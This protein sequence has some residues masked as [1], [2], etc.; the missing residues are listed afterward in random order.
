[1]LP[2]RQ[3]EIDKQ[4]GRQAGTRQTAARGETTMHADRKAGT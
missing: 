2:H 4:K 1:M 3:P